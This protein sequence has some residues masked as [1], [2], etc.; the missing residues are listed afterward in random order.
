MGRLMTPANPCPNDADL[1]SFSLGT[2]TE[3]EAT[4]VEDHLSACPSC[5]RRLDGLRATD[6]LLLA[7]RSTGTAD[8]LEIVSEQVETLIARLRPLCGADGAATPRSP[9]PETAALAGPPPGGELATAQP[10]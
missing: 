1:R 6:D 10:L 9:Q 3:A 8:T 4:A 5:L 7:L 2:D